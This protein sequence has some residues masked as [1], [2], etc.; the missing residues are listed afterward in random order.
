LKMH[1]VGVGSRSGESTSEGP[2]PHPRPRRIQQQLERNYVDDG[3]GV[4]GRTIRFDSEMKVAAG[5]NPSMIIDPPYLS[6]RTNN[7][8]IIVEEDDSLDD[9]FGGGKKNGDSDEGNKGKN[10]AL[11]DDTKKG[12]RNFDENDGHHLS[13]PVNDRKTR[14][15]IM[16]HTTG[17]QD[18]D[19]S[20]LRIRSSTSVPD[21]SEYGA[22]GTPNRELHQAAPTPM[23]MKSTTPHSDKCHGINS[24]N[25]QSHENIK[26]NRRAYDEVDWRTGRIWREDDHTATSGISDTAQTL[27]PIPTHGTHDDSHGDHGLVPRQ[28]DC[29]PPHR[30]EP[31]DELDES[32]HKSTI[33][34]NYGPMGLVETARRRSEPMDN[35]TPMYHP[36][37]LVKRPVAP[38]RPLFK[39]VMEDPKLAH[40]TAPFRIT[41]ISIPRHQKE[42]KKVMMNA[43][44]KKTVHFGNIQI[45]T[46][47]TILGDN[48]SCTNGPPISIGWRYDP[49]HLDMSVDEYESQQLYRCCGSTTLVMPRPEDIVL[50]RR[51]RE[52]ILLRAGRAT[53]GGGSGS[54]YTDQDFAQAIRGVV[55]IKHQR[56]RTVHNLKVAWL[57]ERVEVLTKMFGRCVVRRRP[58]TR[59]LYEQWKKGVQL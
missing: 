53:G 14:S 44:K 55:K 15:M 39:A 49:N 19:Y 1:N 26:G 6:Y 13:Y 18:E 58:R 41:A 47:E 46:H 21:A 8:P 56:L 17:Y 38:P 45:R 24:I 43:K 37:N 29:H 3:G 57:E 22:V 9:Y 4:D 12:E 20:V 10:N 36:V 32:R 33:V 28:M 11:H 51:E 31:M 54:S 30:L 40:K 50:N 27:S 23:Q 25:R 48:P 34:R 42:K 2:R 16:H 7:G 35:T 5:F 52:D 59:H